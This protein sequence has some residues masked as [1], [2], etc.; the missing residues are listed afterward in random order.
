MLCTVGKRPLR[1]LAG[2]L[3]GAV[4]SGW[5]GLTL[6]VF[7][8]PLST[9]RKDERERQR[10]AMATAVATAHTGPKTVHRKPKVGSSIWAFKEKI[11]PSRLSMPKQCCSLTTCIQ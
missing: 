8:C 3:A 9:S 6:C 7:R 10:T 2:G 1:W 5:I 11:D 4:E